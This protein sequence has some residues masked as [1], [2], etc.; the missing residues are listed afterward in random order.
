MQAE[1]IEKLMIAE[2]RFYKSTEKEL[3]EFCDNYF[4]N[5]TEVEQYCKEKF[6][7]VDLKN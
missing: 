2:E 6:I 1:Q 4:S 5:D 7:P 3:D